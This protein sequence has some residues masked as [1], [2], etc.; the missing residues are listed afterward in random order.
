MAGVFGTTVRSVNCCCGHFTYS[1][2]GISPVCFRDLAFLKTDSGHIEESPM[3]AELATSSPA[4]TLATSLGDTAPFLNLGPVS[5]NEPTI[6]QMRLYARLSGLPFWCVVCHA[7]GPQ[8]V[9]ATSDSLAIIPSLQ[10]MAFQNVRGPHV[11]ALESGLTF[12]SLPLPPLGEV[13][14]VAIGWVRLRPD[15]RPD[16]LVFAA[17]DAGWTKRQLDD[18]LQTQPYASPELVQRLLDTTWSQASADYREEI[19]RSELINAGEQLEETY[20]EIT[21]LH[22]LTGSLQLSRTPQELA[23]WSLSRVRQLTRATGAAIF[24]EEHNGQSHFLTDGKMPLRAQDLLH[25]CTRCD[26]RDWSRPFV[27]NRLAGTQLAQELPELRNFVLCSIGE[28]T[29]RFGW[30]IHCNAPREFGSVQASLLQSIAKILG[31]HLQNRQLYSQN[32]GLLTSFVRSMVSTIDAKDSYTRGHSERVALVA[33]CLGEEMGLAAQELEDIH[34]SGLLHDIGKVGVD[35]RILRK[36]ER[37]NEEEFAQ[38]KRHPEMGC[39]ILMGLENLQHVLPGVRH[40]HESFNGGGYPDGLAGTDIPLMARVMAV[41]DA[42]DAMGS[43][44]P[45]RKGMS[46]DR[47]ESTFRENVGPQWDPQIIDAYFRVRVK[48]RKVWSAHRPT[49]LASL[50][51]A[52][53]VSRLRQITLE[54]NAGSYDAQPGTVPRLGDQIVANA[55]SNAATST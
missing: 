28:N 44:R 54:N 15:R 17:V 8:V 55:A 2:S 49:D 37:L 20:E 10:M 51:T 6:K 13:P 25:L 24:F 46:L 35:D 45:Y 7:E 41:A 18:W 47:I 53:S 40:H 1:S 19:L 48:I 22:S 3:I 21:L 43:D 27:K 4:A 39:Q 29:Q 26:K 52:L 23:D 50:S 16:D 5:D 30:L 12:Y 9:A 14:T 31:T 11:E 34:L 32:E 33:K 42:Y 38:I 36:T